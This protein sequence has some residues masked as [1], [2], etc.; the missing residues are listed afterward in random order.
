MNKKHLR[1]LI[2]PASVL[3]LSGCNKPLWLTEI[4]SEQHENV[5]I[6]DITL[7]DD[8]NTYSTGSVQTYF[9]T[10]ANNAAIKGF[11]I[12]TVKHDA[13]GNEVWR[14]TYSSPYERTAPR[15]FITNDDGLVDIFNVAY[16]DDDI[17]PN[18]DYTGGEE[19]LFLLNDDQG[20]TYVVGRIHGENFDAN[21]H[22]TAQD[23]DVVVLKYD[24]QGELAAEL[25][26]EDSDQF[27]AVRNASFENNQLSLAINDQYDSDFL[28]LN[29]DLSI[30][31]SHTLVD[32]QVLN[33]AKTDTGKWVVVTAPREDWYFEQSVSLYDQNMTL[34]WSHLK[35]D[36]PPHR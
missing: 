18:W 30:A 7:D 24:T 36:F 1:T 8:N 12:L 11:D 32:A 6:S 15:Q 10:D 29:P 31:Q 35:P 14:A 25:I 28:V 23:W 27:D 13:D 5:Y 4:F 2:I 9:A 34:E 20:N 26:L 16:I 19:G 3:A 21:Q 17:I 33:F 22:V